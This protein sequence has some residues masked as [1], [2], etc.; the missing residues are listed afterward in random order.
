MALPVTA[1]TLDLVAC[2]ARRGEDDLRVL[3]LIARGENV[4]SGRVAS[5][6]QAGL[7]RGGSPPRLPARLL[8]PVLALEAALGYAGTETLTSLLGLL[9]AAG[10]RSARDAVLVALTEELQEA[11]ERIRSGGEHDQVSLR[12]AIEGIGEA[13]ETIA[14]ADADPALVTRVATGC[15]RV[16]EMLADRIAPGARRQSKPPSYDSKLLATGVRDLV[17]RETRPLAL[18]PLS[19]LVRSLAGEASLPLASSRRETLPVA[20]A[21]DSVDE[22]LEARDPIAALYGGVTL[23]EA[24]RRHVRLSCGGRSTLARHDLKPGER[25]RCG[26]TP[27][28]SSSELANAR[29]EAGID[30]QAEAEAL[31][32]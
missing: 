30:I 1:S 4:E 10:S 31:A 17:C 12:L 16:I 5:L 3:C 2:A 21:R 26:P 11:R 32:A 15:A 29:A 7:V 8:A 14:A 28:R 6:R 19:A 20:T 25:T 23:D 13:L 22:A 9:R 27:L 18:P 24:L